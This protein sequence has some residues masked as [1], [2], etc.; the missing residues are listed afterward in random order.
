MAPSH[1]LD[2]IRGSWAG[3]G[4]FVVTYPGFLEGRV[5]R[6]A[7]TEDLSVCRKALAEGD[8]DTLHI[9]LQNLETSSYRIAEAMYSSNDSGE[10]EGGFATEEAAVDDDADD[11]GDFDLPGEE[12]TGEES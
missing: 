6:Q 12:G 1:R 11:F 2:Y 7:F 8:L 5:S 9:A 4:R 3:P 10:D